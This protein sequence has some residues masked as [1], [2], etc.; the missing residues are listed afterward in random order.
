M[1]A[2]AALLAAAPAAAQVENEAA[3]RALF[4]EGRKLRDA[5]RYEQACPKFEAASKLYGGSG[6]LVNLGDCYE[7]VG[8]TASAWTTFGDAVTLA[9]RLGH[10]D[11][12]TEARR[13]QAALGPR[14]SSLAIH[15]SSEAPGLVVKRDGTPLD[16]PAWGS[17]IPVDPGLH[18]LSAEAPDR[19]AWSSSVSVTGPGR[20][21]TVDVPELETMKPPLVVASSAPPSP[22][23]PSYWTAG[24]VVGV[25]MTGAGLVALGIGGI[26]GLQAKSQYDKAAQE[27]GTARHDDSVKAVNE[28]NVASW[29]VGVG[30]VVA[31][32]GV[33]VWITVPSS[34]TAVGTNGRDVLFLQRF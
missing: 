29:V 31:A 15:V 30:A 1:T 24:R 13:R 23:R 6:L 33:L 16:R 12:E 8:R 14:L 25:T 34:R 27:G 21:V 9:V 18:T 19:V 26:L 17:S 20:T 5:G 4:D 32:A 3:A 11:D 28:G 22:D 2:I 10:S 7:H